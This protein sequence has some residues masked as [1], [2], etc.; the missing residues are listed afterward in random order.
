M[1]SPIRK[2]GHECQEREEFK[3]YLSVQLGPSPGARGVEE[4]DIKEK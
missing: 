4:G 2:N 1:L 3:T